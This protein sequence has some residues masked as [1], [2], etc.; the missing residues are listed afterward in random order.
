VTIA[1]FGYGLNPENSLSLFHFTGKI[2]LIAD[3]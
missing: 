2:D 1:F 3:G